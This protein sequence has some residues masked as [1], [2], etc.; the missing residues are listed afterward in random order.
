MIIVGVDPDLGPQIY[1][2]DPAGY[3]VG[4]HATAAGQK[5][6]EATN[7]LEKAYK[8][9]FNFSSPDDVVE[10]ALA[11]LGQV[12]ATDLKAG[13]VEIGIAEP[14]KVEGARGTFRHVSP[15]RPRSFLLFLA[16]LS[17]SELTLSL[18]LPCAYSSPPRRLPP[19]STGF[20]SATSPCSPASLVDPDSVTYPRLLP[21]SIPKRSC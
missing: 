11:T 6:Q 13:E 3:Y 15:L 21:H 10:H 4:F 17:S 20:Q 8:K 1:K 19:L 14:A 2:L 18:V 9:G 12:L 5:Q 7:V 16:E